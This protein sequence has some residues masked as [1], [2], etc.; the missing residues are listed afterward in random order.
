MYLINYRLRTPGSRTLYSRSRLHELRLTFEASCRLVQRVHP[1]SREHIIEYLVLVNVPSTNDIQCQI[2]YIQ[3]TE[4]IIF[5]MFIRQV[6]DTSSSST[7]LVF[8]LFVGL[9]QIK[10]IRHTRCTYERRPEFL[11]KFSP[12]AE[13]VTYEPV[14]RCDFYV[15]AQVLR[16][17]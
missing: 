1:V 8:T 11:F 6:N 3:A 10:S 13:R 15:Y 5:R 7:F 17:I 9:H 12:I 16:G 14:L 4:E 2:P